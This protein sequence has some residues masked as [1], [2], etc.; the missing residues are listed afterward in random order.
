[1]FHTGSA[2]GIRPSELSPPATVPGA[3]PPERTHV[4]IVHP[5][6]N[7]A[8]AARPARMTAASGL[9]PV[10]ESLAADVL[11]A[12]QPPAAPLGFFPF[13]ACG[14]HDPPSFPGVLSRAFRRSVK[15][16]RM[17]PQSF[18]SRR[19]V[20]SRAVRKARLGRTAFLGFPHLCSPRHSRIGF[21]GLCVHLTPYGTLPPVAA[22]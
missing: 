16:N 2:P 15:P 4:P 20:R 7:A 13:K 22:L 8:E 12:R 3:F 14:R 1:M 9:R 21:A 18:D 11:L 10:L 5:V 17:A 6:H 19:L